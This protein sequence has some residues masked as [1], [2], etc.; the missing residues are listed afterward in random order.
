MYD[1]ISFNDQVNRNKN[2]TQNNVKYEITVE[3]EILKVR[4]NI[5]S[6]YKPIQD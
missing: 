3:G 6:I 2:V 5:Q 4:M 1:L